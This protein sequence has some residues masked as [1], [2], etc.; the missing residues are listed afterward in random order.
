MKSLHFLFSPFCF[1]LI[2]GSGCASVPKANPPT[3]Q[4]E[5]TPRPTP[6]L[7]SVT[8]PLDRPVAIPAVYKR[9]YVGLLSDGPSYRF[10]HPPSELIVREEGDR[11]AANASTAGLSAGPTLGYQSSA[12]HPGANAAAGA[13]SDAWQQPRGVVGAGVGHVRRCGHSPAG[14]GGCQ[15]QLPRRRSHAEVPPQGCR[16]QGRSRRPGDTAQDTAVVAHMMGKAAMAKIACLSQFASTRWLH[17]SRLFRASSGAWR[18]TEAANLS[19]CRLPVRVRASTRLR[20]SSVC[21]RSS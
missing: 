6:T 16:H 21:S 17:P 15:A 9:Y 4:S 13:A 18:R 7:H 10:A 20:T 11:W 19:G 12:F 2:L 14:L 8:L 1:F 3:P 5:S